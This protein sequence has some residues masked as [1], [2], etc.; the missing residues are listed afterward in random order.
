MALHSGR[1]IRPLTLGFV[2]SALAACGGGGGS[3]SA[4]PPVNQTPTA[5]V[6]ASVSRG[7]LPLTV[8]FSGSNST[9]DGTITGYAWDFGDGATA[10]GELVSHT[11]TTPGTF[12]VNLTVTDNGGLT[13]AADRSIVVT[14]TLSGTISI[15][16]KSAIDSDVNDRVATP[17]ANNSLADAQP[18]P[19]PVS[20]GGFVNQ[21]NRGAP[22]GNLFSSGDLVDVY[23]LSLAG[24]ER[25]LLDIA[26]PLADLD[27]ELIDD[28]G[29]LVDESIGITSTE[30]LVVPAP[31]DYFVAVSAFRGASNYV[32]SIGRDLTVTARSATR[33]SDPMVPGELLL[34]SDDPTTATRHGMVTAGRSGPISRLL[35]PATNAALTPAGATIPARLLRPR[36]TLMAIKTL[37]RDPAVRC[38]EPN[39]LRRA[40]RVPNDTFYPRQWHLP[41]INLPTAWDT[42]IG[43]P[44]VVVA[45]VDTGVLVNHPDLNDLIV[46][47]F[48]FISDPARANDGDGI[49]PNPDDPGDNS[50]A[51]SSSFHGTHVAGTVAAESDNGSGVT[52]VAWD[53]RLMPI[54][55]LGVDGGT[56]FDVIE[57]V[58]YAAGL[59]NGSGTVPANPADIINLSL[60]GGG[61]GSAAEQSTYDQVRAAGVIV[62]ASAG[63]DASATPSFPAAYDGVVSV[64]A[65]TITNTLAPYSNFGNTIDI[66]APGG[67]NATDVNADGIGDGVIST[68]GDDSTNPVSFAFASLNGTSMAAPHVA[69]VAALMKSVHPG[70]TPAEFDDALAAGALTDDL[71]P[72]GR[73]DRFGFGLINATKAVA[74]AVDLATGGGVATGPILRLS[75]TSVN[76]GAFLTQET[77]TISDAGDGTA[78]VL[79]VT[80]DQPWLQVAALTVDAAGLG[81]YRLTVD[82]TGLADGVYRGTVTVDGAASDLT[83]SVS[84]Q[85]NTGAPDADAGIQFVIAVDSNNTTVAETIATNVGGSYSYTITR[86]PADGPV[87]II[88]G[89]DSDDDGFLCDAGEACG[90]F[91][92]IDTPNRV[93]TDDNQVG[94]DFLTTFETSL[95]S[96]GASAADAQDDQAAQDGYRIDKTALDG[97]AAQAAPSP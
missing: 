74:T 49:D 5:V 48:D 31:G 11:F 70:L 28:A 53:V 17:V 23:R 81:E 40:H 88:A 30:S 24:D 26:D 6:G 44:D 43:S 60:G 63:N 4:P 80:D 9:D 36:E 57:G 58:R 72:A 21:P 87:S 42:T 64:S 77:I 37:A 86:V 34:E 76:F 67:N 56:S 79:N 89:T 19:N 90:A 47:G 10:S 27:M 32:L 46:P 50:F 14:V 92:T 85:V 38:A 68:I 2:G 71:G 69:G 39:L 45:V 54:R 35:V 78:Q 33:L 84:M 25:I 22:S 95:E 8:D 83:L 12:T 15:P 96:L 20:L 65:S 13:G 94:L 91:R 51:G 82:R 52:G 1:L 41:Q 16:G 93:E 97:D 7:D 55:V 18:L 3:S 61:I 75:S 59:S 66:A 62:I 73:D 29:M